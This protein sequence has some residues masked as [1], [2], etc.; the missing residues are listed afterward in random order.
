MVVGALPAFARGTFNGWTYLEDGGAK[1]KVTVSVTAAGKI[2]AKVGSLSFSRTGWAV[3]EDGRYSAK[4]LASR[5]VG[6]GK[7]AKKY[8]DVLVLTLDPEAPWTEDQLTG[9]VAT[10]NGSLALADALAAWED[11]TRVPQN[12]DADVSARRQRRGQGRRGGARCAGDAAGRRRVGACLEREGRVDR[13][14]HDLPRDGIGE[15]QED[16]FG[17][18]SRER[19]D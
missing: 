1:R 4:M 11:G 15:E 10:F 16:G 2:S 7:S 13:R 12:A 9:S 3:G 5:T 8:S 6:T 17:H 14:G 19:A 18:G